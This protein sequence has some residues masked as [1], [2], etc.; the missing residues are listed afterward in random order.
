MR[1][2]GGRALTVESSAVPKS[3]KSREDPETELSALIL[4][5]TLRSLSSGIR[6]GE[7]KREESE[8]NYQTQS[9]KLFVPTFVS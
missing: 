9:Q 7:G 6:K 3:A 2:K 4:L 1:R 8:Q 5:A